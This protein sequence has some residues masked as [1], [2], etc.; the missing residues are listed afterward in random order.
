MAE[1]EN[2]AVF[3]VPGMEGEGGYATL[4]LEEQILPARRVI[5]AKAIDLPRRVLRHHEAILRGILSDADGLFE[6][7]L[8]ERADQPVLWWRIGGANHA[9][10]SPLF[11]LVHPERLPAIRQHPRYVDQ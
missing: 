3:A 6:Y 4:H 9:R 5:R 8:I 2:I 7:K 11:A 1:H 10:R